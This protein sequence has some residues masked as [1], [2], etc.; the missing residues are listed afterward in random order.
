MA[1]KKIV[2]ETKYTVKGANGVE[3]A[4]EGISDSA[5]DASNSTE[6][7]NDNIE[8]T[9]DSSK[10]AKSGL[11]SL[12]DGF[13]AIVANPIGLTLVALVGAIRFVSN[14]LS[15]SEGASNKLSQ[16]FAY[17][18][19]FIQPLTNAILTGFESIAEAVAE[20]GKAWDNFVTGF[21]NSVNYVKDNILAPYLSGWKILG[22][23]VS[24][25]IL[26]MRI[27]WNEFTGDVEESDELQT[28]LD[29]VNESIGENVKIIQ[30][31]SKT[32]KDDVVG[33]YNAVVEGVTNYIDEADKLGDA[34]S[35][36][37]RREQQLLVVR[38]EQEVQNAKA[39][40]DIEAL[41]IIRDDEAQSLQDRIKANEDIAKIEQTR[42][43]N[44][45]SLAQRE[46]ALVRENIALRGASTEFLD[47]EKDALIAVQE[48]RSESAGIENEQIVNKT[49]LLTEEFDK[50]ASL[51]DKEQELL[52][53]REEDAV[54]LAEA[55]VQA[56]RDKLIALEELGLQEK[57][58]YTDQLNALEIAQATFI[59]AQKEADIEASEAKKELD[60]KNTADAIKLAEDTAKEKAKIEQ[61]L[62]NQILNFANSLSTALGEESKSALLIQK[63]VALAQIGIDTAK[64]ISSLTAASS[65]N[66]ANAVTFGGAG[67]IQF[68]TGLLQIGSN[69]AQ[70]YALLKAPAPSLGSGDSGDASA[71]P[72]NT[73]QTA[74]DLGFEGRSAGS[75]N[76]G[77]QVIKA[78]ITESD[79]TTAQTNASNI[80]DLS[81]IG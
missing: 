65:A 45:I 43:T 12:L 8:Q 72:P 80:Q 53:I 9:G 1:K 61:A 77:A 32:L 2:V 13:K 28:K 16:G 19:G 36:L 24:A 37:V 5:N 20:P 59:Q 17:L 69:I 64:A 22:L 40:A 67:A 23:G 68:A 73:Q 78:Y 3:D 30:D 50:Q 27:A 11:G 29:E 48:L 60:E 62:G 26:K 25:Q 57:Q 41:K 76:F 70:A 35:D 34:L 56:Q 66:P 6:K 38:R 7:L 71:P 15:S 79:V 33:A 46:L 58:L 54:K 75:E 42:I 14:A 49:A 44:A 74:P 18:Q 55:Q 63:T 39:L 10:K 47:A 81:Q 51:I 21:E 4:Y 31:A 52:A